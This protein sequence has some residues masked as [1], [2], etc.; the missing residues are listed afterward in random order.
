VVWQVYLRCQL[1]I[2]RWASIRIWHMVSCGHMYTGFGCTEKNFVWFFISHCSTSYWAG[3]LFWDGTKCTSSKWPE[4][5][6][7]TVF[8][9]HV[10]MVNLSSSSVYWNMYSCLTSLALTVIYKINNNICRYPNNL[11]DNYFCGS[12]GRPEGVSVASIETLFQNFTLK[13]WL[14]FILLVYK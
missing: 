3:V 5:D 12:S 4:H 14:K 10:E 9:A 13:F 6:T 7:V 11:L 1:V 2:F 8:A